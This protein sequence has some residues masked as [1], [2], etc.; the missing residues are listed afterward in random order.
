MCAN[1]KKEKAAHI[2]VDLSKTLINASL[3]AFITAG[4]FLR[5]TQIFICQILLII[6]LI[7]FGTSCFV[8]GFAISRLYKNAIDGDWN[9]KENKQSC[10][11]NAQAWL[12]LVGLVLLFI[13]L[14]LQFLF[15][16]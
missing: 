3:I 10:L 13:S 14:F 5:F 2:A 15:D 12:S 11:F 1:N 7:L 6:S 16:Y 9:V 8:G 4:A